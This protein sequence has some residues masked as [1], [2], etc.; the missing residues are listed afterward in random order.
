MLNLTLKE[1]FKIF[2]ISLI[3][4]INHFYNI[5]PNYHLAL[6]EYILQN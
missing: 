1:L 2:N 5:N 3:L 6:I 4:L